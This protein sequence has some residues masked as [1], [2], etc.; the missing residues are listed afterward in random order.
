MVHMD[1]TR[2]QVQRKAGRE[3]TFN[4]WMWVAVGGEN[5]PKDGRTHGM[6]AGCDMD[7]VNEL[8]ERR[9]RD[10]PFASMLPL[11]LGGLLLR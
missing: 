1:E 10:R 9:F 3:N 4:S 7:W 11:R 2:M 6:L 8:L 5:S